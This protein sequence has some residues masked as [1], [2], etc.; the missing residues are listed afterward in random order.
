V[1]A[2]IIRRL[3]ILI[4]TLFIVSL[5]I[6]FMVRFIPGDIVDAGVLGSSSHR[7]RTQRKGRGRIPSPSFISQAVL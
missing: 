7:L 3:L 2:Y 6:F 4:P 1:R 5:M